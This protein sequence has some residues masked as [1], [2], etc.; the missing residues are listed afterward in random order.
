MSYRLYCIIF[1]QLVIQVFRTYVTHLQN[2]KQK[3][4]DKTL[5]LLHKSHGNKTLKAI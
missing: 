1:I 3:I 4:Q 2:R 5:N